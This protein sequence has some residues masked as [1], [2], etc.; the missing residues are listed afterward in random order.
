[1]AIIKE[2]VD[3]MNYNMGE[4][5][6]PGVFISSTCGD[7]QPIRH[8]V[9]KFIEDMGYEAIL[10]EYDS[11]PIDPSRDTVD[12]CIRVIEKRADMM[13]LIIGKRYGYV[14]DHGEKSITYLEYL[15]AKAK[16]IPIFAFIERGLIT[17]LPVWEKNK[18]AD[19]SDT[20]D[21]PKVFEFISELR[22][23][24]GRWTFEFSSGQ[25]IVQCLKKQWAYVFNDGL[26][27]KRHF[28]QE[29]ISSKILRYSGCVFEIAVEKPKYWEYLLFAE[30]LKERLAELE[31]LRNDLKYGISFERTL[32]LEKPIEIIDYVGLKCEDLIRKNDMIN[33]LINK[34]LK[35]ALGEMGV[36]GD[37]EYIIYVAEKLIEVYKC[38]HLWALDFKCIDVPE[39]FE[40]LIEY[41]SELSKSVIQDIERFIDNY[42]VTMKRIADG[43]EDDLEGKCVSFS[44][45]LSTPDMTNINAELDK[46]HTLII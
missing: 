19:F 27:L 34:A 28:S 41:S 20:V 42:S 5:R 40:K 24:S 13:V 11:F 14:T 26:Y 15:R 23:K 1:M 25:E 12:N 37:A 9:K 44:L 17:M 4:A 35:E 21:S 32:C 36:D 18:D 29:N 6:R 46:L 33:I 39:S 43:L 2:G 45:T 8:D 38:N 16:G 22:V 31:D 7:L 30:V 3:L 10:S